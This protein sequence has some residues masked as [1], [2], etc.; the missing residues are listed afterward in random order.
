M[1]TSGF[2][3]AVFIEDNSIWLADTGMKNK[4]VLVQGDAAAM[5][6]N[7]VWGPPAIP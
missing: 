6:R 4:R 7:P 2:G 5:L 3:H 1:W